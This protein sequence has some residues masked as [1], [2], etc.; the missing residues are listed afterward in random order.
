MNWQDFFKLT[1]TKVGRKGEEIFFEAELKTPVDF[2]VNDLF[3][4]RFDHLKLNETEKKKFSLGLRKILVCH[5]L[6]ESYQFKKIC[7]DFKAQ[8]LACESDEITF[9]TQGGGIYLFL[10][11]MNDPKLKHKKITCYTSELPLPI[12]G[13]PLSRHIQFIYRPH[14]RSYLSDFSTLWKESE[15]LS[16]FELKDF[17][18][19]A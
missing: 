4:S 7:R 19:S 12:A 5:E 14:A 9:S 3:I 11:I 16:L 17:K 10:S 15:V 2:P 1:V 6:F 18:A 8:I 13:M